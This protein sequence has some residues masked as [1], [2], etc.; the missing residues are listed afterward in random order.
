MQG[1]VDDGKTATMKSSYERNQ[2][3]LESAR[4][5]VENLQAEMERS[6]ASIKS[7]QDELKRAQ[8]TAAKVEVPQLSFLPP[9]DQLESLLHKIDQ[10]LEVR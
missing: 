7:L 10:V 6:R 3:E 5:A 9:P 2:Q 8:V 1:R 4:R